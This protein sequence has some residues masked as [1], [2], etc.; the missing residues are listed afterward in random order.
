MTA[1]SESL[2][3]QNQ[4]AQIVFVSLIPLP[5]PRRAKWSV[6]PYSHWRV[7]LSEAISESGKQ[8]QHLERLLVAMQFVYQLSLKVI[9]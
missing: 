8:V 9:H 4:V 2:R 7:S 5:S 3:S 1:S 6:E